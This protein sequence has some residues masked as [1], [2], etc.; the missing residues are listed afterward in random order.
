MKRA[1]F[2]IL[3]AFMVI[4]CNQHTKLYINTKTYIDTTTIEKISIVNSEYFET[5]FY[6]MAVF[7]DY[8]AQT[9]SHKSDAMIIIYVTDEKGETVRFENSME[10]LNFMSERGYEMVEQDKKQN[11]TIY[12]FKKK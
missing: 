3:F 6:L 7:N 12:T 2:V 9:E 11:K 5:G 4:S 1:L 10:F 8:T